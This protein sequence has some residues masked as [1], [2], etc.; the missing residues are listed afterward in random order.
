MESS[1][2]RIMMKHE[3]FMIEQCQKWEMFMLIN[4]KKKHPCK[5]PFYKKNKLTKK[6]NNEKRRY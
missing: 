5:M 6:R 4:A 3:L 2:S 1:M